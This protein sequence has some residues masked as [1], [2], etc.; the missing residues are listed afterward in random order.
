L[1]RLRAIGHRE[2]LVIQPLAPTAAGSLLIK[3]AQAVKTLDDLGLI[4]RLI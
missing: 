2:Y 3:A 1:T 4:I